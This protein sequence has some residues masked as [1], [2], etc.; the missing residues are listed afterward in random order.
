MNL[1]WGYALEATLRWPNEFPQNMLCMFWNNRNSILILCIVPCQNV[2]LGIC[3]QRRPRS[4]CAS[5][6]SDQG[7]Y[8]LLTESLDTTECMNGE[9][10][11]GWYFVHAL[12]VYISIFCAC[13]KAL[14][15]LTRPTLWLKNRVLSGEVYKSVNV[16]ISRSPWHF[17]QMNSS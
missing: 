17:V 8:C 10:K 15:P 12:M 11:P 3:R 1:L 16:M 13:L 14:F 5:G 4:T 2:T 9:P 7:L 6:Q